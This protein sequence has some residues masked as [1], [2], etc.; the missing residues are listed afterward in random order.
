VRAGKR[1]DGLRDRSDRVEDGLYRPDGSVAGRNHEL[2]A[3]LGRIAAI[4][5]RRPA[6]PDEAAR[7]SA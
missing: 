3:E 2:V 7:S 4:Y 1:R 5:G 6:T